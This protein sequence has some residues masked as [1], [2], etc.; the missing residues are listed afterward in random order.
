MSVKQQALQY[1]DPRYLN[2]KL[3]E[4][5]IYFEV[6]DT[7][8]IPVL[9]QWV[10]ETTNPVHF[11]A[12]VFTEAYFESEIEAEKLLELLTRFW[13]VT[14][15]NELGGLSPQEKFLTHIKDTHT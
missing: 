13:N 3:K 1:E 5:L 11:I 14:P 8:S 2:E 15:R 6:A 4:A 9:K 7:L 12:R 10:Q